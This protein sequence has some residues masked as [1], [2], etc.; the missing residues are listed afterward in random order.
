MISLVVNTLAYIYPH[1]FLTGIS[2]FD[3]YDAYPIIKTSSKKDLFVKRE[4][5]ASIEVVSNEDFV[6]DFPQGGSCSGNFGDIF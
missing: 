5:Y 4:K 2:F 3:M 6:N 1:I